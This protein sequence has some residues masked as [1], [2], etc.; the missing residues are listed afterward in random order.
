MK[1]WHLF[2]EQEYGCVNYRLTS[3]R[4]STTFV[5]CSE[6]L[7]SFI[8]LIG[9]PCVLYRYDDSGEPGR[10]DSWSLPLIATT[11]SANTFIR[12][13]ALTYVTFLLFFSDVSFLVLLHFRVGLGNLGSAVLS[14]AAN[15]PSP[16]IMNDQL[17]QMYGVPQFSSKGHTRTHAHT[18]THLLHCNHTQVHMYCDRVYFIFL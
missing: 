4:C 11:R 13:H 5:L 10:H 17:M 3:S 16:K 7:V 2:F 6:C 18:H 1:F 14:A 8:G 15:N 9:S 12:V